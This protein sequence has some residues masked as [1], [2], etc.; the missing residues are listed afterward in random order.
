M[1][2]P[3]PCVTWSRHR[4]RLAARVLLGVIAAYYLLAWLPSL[5]LASLAFALDDVS[6]S[7]LGGVFGVQAIFLHTNQLVVPVLFGWR[8]RDELH[9]AL[10]APASKALEPAV[11]LGRVAAV[12]CGTD[13]LDISWSAFCRAEESAESPARRTA[14]LLAE[15]LL[16]V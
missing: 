10:A 15:R 16:P 6:S 14:D 8:L 12:R 13:G 4:A 2:T 9:A 3:S 7:P 11:S 5:L 1:K